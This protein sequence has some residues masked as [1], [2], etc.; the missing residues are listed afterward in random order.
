MRQ[1]NLPRWEGWHL[2]GSLQRNKARHAAGRFVLIHSVDRPD[3]A[4]DCFRSFRESTRSGADTLY[5]LGQAY[6]AL[7]DRV[8]ASK[9]Y[10]QVTGFSDHPL[11]SD[12]YDALHRMEAQGST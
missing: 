10:K 7:G 5:K 1:V 6:E 2:I 12:A 9:Y 3:L 11:A 8:R 4:V